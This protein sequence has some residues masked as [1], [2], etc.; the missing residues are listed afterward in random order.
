MKC[1]VEDFKTKLDS[2]LTQILDPPKIGGL[3]QAACDKYTCGPSSPIED[4]AR[5]L[6]MSRMPGT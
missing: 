5:A 4:Q 2:Y 6:K 3:I 1:S